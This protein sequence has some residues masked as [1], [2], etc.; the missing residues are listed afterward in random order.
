MTMYRPL[1]VIEKEQRELGQRL[2]TLLHEYTRHPAIASKTA[3]DPLDAIRLAFPPALV[4][5]LLDQ[6]GVTECTMFVT[7]GD[8][9]PEDETP[10]WNFAA[11]RVCAADD[12][13][14]WFSCKIQLDTDEI[15]SPYDFD[16]IPFH[17]GDPL[18]MWQTAMGAN[19]DNPLMALAAF[20]Y[21]CGNFDT[22]LPTR[23]FPVP[24]DKE[25]CLE[26]EGDE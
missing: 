1:V 17:P 13:T 12:S 22:C 4:P 11:K 25:D 23:A 15:L 7:V 10:V 5:I 6:Y 26:E 21:A 18:G 2:L 14:D 9:D 8:Y 3:G 19:D 20:A 24:R 16:F